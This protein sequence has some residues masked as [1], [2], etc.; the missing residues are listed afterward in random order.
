MLHCNQNKNL[1]PLNDQQSSSFKHVD[2]TLVTEHVDLKVYGY[3]F[4]GSNCHLHICFLSQEGF[5]LNGKN[6]LLLE[7]ILSFQSRPQFGRAMSA[8]EATMKSRQLFPLVK[9]T[10]KHGCVHIRLKVWWSYTV[11]IATVLL[12][13]SALG[14]SLFRHTPLRKCFENFTSK[15]LKTLIKEMKFSIFLLKT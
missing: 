1:D 2:F 3:T 14:E 10:E 8:R 13:T 6:L 7:Y 9:M 11:V 4:R 12:Y 15:K 5:T